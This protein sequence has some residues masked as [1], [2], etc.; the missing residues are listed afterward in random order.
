MKLILYGTAMDSR[1]FSM[2][3]SRLPE[4]SYRSITV[5]DYRD[6]DGFI[7]GLGESP[8]AAVVVMRD[9]AE[10]MEGVM[11]AKSLR[12]GVPVIWLSDDRGFGAQSYRLGCTFF[13]SKPVPPETLSLAME[14]C[15]DQMRAVSSEVSSKEN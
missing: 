4:H 7:A 5:A 13:H 1:M 9:G 14:R 2:A 15:I 12:P 11:A 10:G 6:Y 8:P 3:L